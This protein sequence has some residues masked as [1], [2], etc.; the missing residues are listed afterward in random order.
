MLEVGYMLAQLEAISPAVTTGE[1]RRK[2]NTEVESRM[3]HP[4][5]SAIWTKES[6]SG[7]LG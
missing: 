6:K 5:S 3:G 1:G 7:K 2:Q 4:S